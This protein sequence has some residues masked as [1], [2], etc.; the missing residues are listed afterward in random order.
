MDSPFHTGA[1]REPGPSL[2]DRIRRALDDKDLDALAELYTEDAT[3]EEVSSL[4][5]PSH[6]VVLHGRDA[7]RARLHREILEDPISGW[8]R[9]LESATLVDGLETADAVAFTELRTYAAGDKAVAQH[10]AHKHGGRIERD[11]VVCAWDAD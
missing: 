7:I 6:P 3:L 8:T 9:Q 11:R 4:S 10:V 1:G 5:P 2:L